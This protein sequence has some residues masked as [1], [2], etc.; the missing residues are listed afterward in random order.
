[1]SST[2]VPPTTVRD[3]G[4]HHR[5]ASWS[6]RTRKFPILNSGEIDDMTAKLGIAPPEMIF[7]NNSVEVLHEPIGWGIV[8]NA[9]DALDVVDKTGEAGMLK[10][11]Y[12]EQ[13][14]KMRE[15]VSEEIKEVVRPFDWSYSTGWRGRVVGEVGLL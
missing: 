5:I 9:F 3:A 8:F 7:G 2:F 12:S 6:I 4:K 15:K 14:Q 1:M 11:A 13:W 10:V